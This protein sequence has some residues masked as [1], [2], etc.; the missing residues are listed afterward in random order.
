MPGHWVG[1]MKLM[2]KPIDWFAFDY[3]PISPSHIHGIFEGGSMGN[4]FTSFFVADY[5][6]TKTIMARNGGILSGFYR[7]SYFVLDK[8]DIKNNET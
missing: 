5:K 2:G 1:K 7:T 8:I 3:R 4:L 6:G